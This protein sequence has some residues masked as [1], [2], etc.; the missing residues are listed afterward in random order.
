MSCAVF[1]ARQKLS[2]GITCAGGYVAARPLR[3]RTAQ[4][5]ALS[6]EY[7]NPNDPDTPISFY[8]QDGKLILESERM[9]PTALTAD[10]AH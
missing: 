7:T 6:G 8:T 1:L 10:F 4:L 5:D 2:A 3:F 9:V